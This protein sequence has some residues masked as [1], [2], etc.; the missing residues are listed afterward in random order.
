[1]Y[2]RIASMLLTLSVLVSVT[3]CI[4][5]RKKVAYDSGA[6]SSS[7]FQIPIKD[8]YD[9]KLQRVM[10]DGENV[11]IPV[12]YSRYDSNHQEVLEVVTD[13]YTVTTDG[14]LVYTLEVMGAQPPDAIIDGEYVYLGYSTNRN[15][16]E[17][18]KASAVFLDKNTG[19]LTRTV[20]SDFAPRYI[21]DLTDGFALVG[22]SEIS[23][24]SKDGVLV[25]EVVTDFQCYSGSRG[26]FEDNGKYFVIEEEDML[27][28]TYHEVDFLSGTCSRKCS[29]T[30]IGIVTSEIDGQYF[31]N[32]D[33]EYKVDL[34]NMKVGCIADW[35][36]IDIRPPQG[37]L[38]TPA[39][40]YHLDDNRFALSYEYR[41][42]Y[43]TT[44]VLI[45]HYD[46]S[47]DRTDVDTIRIG[48]F[49]VY[50]DLLLQWMV[51]EFNT[52]NKEFRVVLEDYSDE[53]GG[54]LNDSTKGRLDLMKYF[55]QGNAPDIFYGPQFDYDYMGHNEMIVDMAEYVNNS[56]SSES[57]GLTDTARKLFFNDQGACYQVFAAYM[58]NGYYMK[59]EVARE[60]GDMSFMSAFEYAQE[61]EITYSF[62]PPADIIDECIRYSFP[63]L[64]GVYDGQQKITK[65]DLEKMITAVVSIPHSDRMLATEDDVVN[66]RTL[67]F[68]MCCGSYYDEAYRQENYQEEF[69]FV[70]Y[71]S[72]HGSIH[73]AVPKCQMGISTTAKNK[74]KCWEVIS[75]LFSPEVQEQAVLAQGIPVT[76]QAMDKLCDSIMH[77]EAS[78]IASWTNLYGKQKPGDQA[79][80]DKLLDEVASA[81]VVATYDWGIA[82]IIIDEIDSYYT[83]SRTPAQIA[84]TLFDRLTLYMKENYT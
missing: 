43:G 19:D 80:L 54:L 84:D 42:D 60:I 78:T 27:E 9:L 63:D 38:N 83:Q 28:Y 76:S 21:V 59:E 41:D 49:G 47:I 82:K 29:S 51:Y 36:S 2:K 64:W 14:E 32:P 62:I 81:D 11:C 1:M 45:F 22:E 15:A 34:N 26:F 37:A 53:F 70:G 39:K 57:G 4:Q 7:T 48:G 6:Y 56:T 71:P 23:K 74:E 67:M 30:E 17:T 31:F 25:G 18:D 55:N 8:G 77:P 44:E 66:G 46:S 73:L 16:G 79:L 69:V 33:G 65:D 75:M 50:D 24:Y 12:V 35:N 3:G 13:V 10:S 52:S 20:E 61:H 68:P 58:L 5:Q 40:R 72:V